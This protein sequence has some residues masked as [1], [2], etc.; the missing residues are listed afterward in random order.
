MITLDPS[1]RFGKGLHRE[2]FVHPD[3][4]DLCIKVVTY[5]NQQETQREQ[6]YYQQLQ[7]R[8]VAWD[9]LPRFH[10]NVETSIGS[11]AVFDLIRDHD[12]Q[13]SK[14][15]EFYLGSDDFLPAQK[16]QLDT[17]LVELRKYLLKYSIMSMAMKPKN[18]VYQLSESGQ[19]KLFIIDNI[20]NSDLIPICNYVPYLA[21]KKIIR[22]WDRFIKKFNL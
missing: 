11:G 4:N 14:T 8:K 1:T 18:I 2:C 12:G 22:R 21:N 10:D 15:L 13:I 16:Q 19:G 17:A 20:G 5:G 9:L 7:K 6:H 3:D